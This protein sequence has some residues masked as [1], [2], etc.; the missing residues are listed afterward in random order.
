M[1]VRAENLEKIYSLELNVVKHRPAV[2][3]IC[4]PNRQLTNL[5]ENITFLVQIILHVT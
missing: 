3:L 1:S 5:N 2:L 4:R